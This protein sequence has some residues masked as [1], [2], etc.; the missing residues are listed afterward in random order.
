MLKGQCK[1]AEKCLVKKVV[2][3]I[4]DDKLC[5]YFSALTY[6]DGRDFGEMC[7]DIYVQV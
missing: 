1:R 7:T 4:F 6:N 3:K 2:W 5:D